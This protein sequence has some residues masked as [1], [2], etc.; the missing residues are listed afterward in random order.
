MATLPL[1]IA[2]AA[3]GGS[4]NFSGAILTPTAQSV[5]APTTTAL[6][7]G[8]PATMAY[9]ERKNGPPRMVKVNP[10]KQSGGQSEVVVTYL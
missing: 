3:I 9:L 6:R 4:I 10:P 1:F 2:V 5:V 8:K 7:H